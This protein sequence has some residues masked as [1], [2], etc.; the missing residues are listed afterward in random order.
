MNQ[1]FEWGGR[2]LALFDHPYN[3]T[4]TNERAVEIP[5]AMEFFRRHDDE[6]GLGRVLEVGNVLGH[7]FE[8]EHLPPDRAVVDA[9]EIQRG[10][11]NVDVFQA[12][13]AGAPFDTIVSISTFE[14]VRWDSAYTQ[15]GLNPYGP[16]AALH[17]VRGLLTPGGKMLATWLWG[18]NGP[19]D[20]WA[21]DDDD[22]SALVRDEHGW[23][24]GWPLEKPDRAVV[25][26]TLE[27]R[28]A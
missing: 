6:A 4:I 25:I 16:L 14:H 5:I 13:H 8:A 11:V 24:D 22:A 18:Y 15:G 17:Y 7:Y 19:L 1:T 21:L 9:H 20:E 12:E 2:E 3:A 23:R 27:G 28:A 26:A 10:V